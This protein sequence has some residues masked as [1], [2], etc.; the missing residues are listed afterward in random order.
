VQ[1]FVNQI[2]VFFRSSKLNNILYLSNP[3]QSIHSI[4]AFTLYVNTDL[5]TLVSNIFILLSKEPVTSKFSSILFHFT[6]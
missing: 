6:L 1:I 3:D 4:S 5:F 2:I